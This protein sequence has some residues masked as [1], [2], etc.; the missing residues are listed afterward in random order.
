MS[1]NPE[2]EGRGS[3]A[4]DAWFAEVVVERRRSEVERWWVP[5]MLRTS[6]RE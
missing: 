2:L 5:E 3:V 6:E 4:C 1:R